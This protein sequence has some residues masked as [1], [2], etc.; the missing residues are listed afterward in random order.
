MLIVC[1]CLVAGMRQ[2]D[3][4]CSG[5]E[6]DDLRLEH[7]THALAGGRRCRVGVHGAEQSPQQRRQRV[8]V[9]SEST[10]GRP[11]QEAYDGESRVIG[12]NGILCAS[13]LRMDSSRQCA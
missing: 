2:H 3:W 11:K 8:H 6:A 1:V 10:S 4:D 9:P 7:G 13:S 5:I 12:R